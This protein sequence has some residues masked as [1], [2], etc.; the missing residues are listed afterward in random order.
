M[1]KMNILRLSK[2]ILHSCKYHIYTYH[3]TTG[4]KQQ[5]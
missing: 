1:K 4:L 5:H 3:S 2:C